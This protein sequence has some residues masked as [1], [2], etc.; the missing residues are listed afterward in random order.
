MVELARHNA[1]IYGVENKIEFVVGDFFQLVPYLKP[2]EEL[3]I[4]FGKYQ[5]AFKATMPKQQ[6]NQEDSRPRLSQADIIKRVNELVSKTSANI[7]SALSDQ[8][9]SRYDDE[10]TVG[11][12]ELP[13]ERNVASDP[14]EGRSP[15]IGG[16]SP[17]HGDGG[18][19][20]QPRAGKHMRFIT[21]NNIICSNIFIYFDFDFRMITSNVFKPEKFTDLSVKGTRTSS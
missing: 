13:S 4:S 7:K 19:S 17:M 21:C 18:M 8:P 9:A 11:I 16:L 5:Y 6:Q 10:G 12:T 3:L 20:S 15:E 2:M 1:R 14:P